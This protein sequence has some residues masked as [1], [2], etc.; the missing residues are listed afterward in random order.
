M[1]D[2][3][4][5][6]SELM[7]PLRPKRKK[8]LVDYLVQFRWIVMIFV[9]LP[10]SFALYFMIYLGDVRLE[11][12]SFKRRRKEHVENVEKV[13]TRLQNRDPRKDGLLCTARKPYLAIGLRNA[14]YKRA[15]HFQVDLS[16]FRNVLD[17]DREKMTAV[18]EPLVNMGQITRVNVP[19]NLS[20]SVVA[21]LDD[22]TVGGLI[23]GYGIEG[24]SHIYGLFSHT[25]VSMGL[26]LA[27]G[28]VVRATKDNE[29]SDLFYAVPWSQ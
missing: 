19:M 28:R 11:M 20:L 13:V 22:L 23:N 27:D 18:V 25:L 4:L 3:G 2:L 21:E 24:R 5:T 8:V 9:V 17:I 6:M 7:V 1:P 16:S 14:D 26:V 10:I 12:K 29:Y 15:R